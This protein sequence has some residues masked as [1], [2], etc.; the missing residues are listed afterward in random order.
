VSTYVFH[1]IPVADGA[2]HL[3][4]LVDR[5]HG[6]V[7]IGDVMFADAAARERARSRWADLWDP[8]EFYWAGDE[9]LEALRG[10]G[11]DGAFEPISACG[12]VLV[13]SR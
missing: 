12:G 1:E 11:L 10:Q 5:S 13:V 6:P 8:D 2:I 7:V 3:G 9:A 4:R